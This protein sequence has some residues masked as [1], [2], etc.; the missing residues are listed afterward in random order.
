MGSTKRYQ[1]PLG[2]IN[3]ASLIVGIVGTQAALAHGV[4]PSAS[5]IEVQSCR[6]TSG[7]RT[8]LKVDFTNVKAPA[9]DKVHFAVSYGEQHFELMDHGTFSKD[10]IIAHQFSVPYDSSVGSTGATCAVTYVH[11]V[12]GSTW[13]RHA[14]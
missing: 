12:D 4:M 11:F 8:I 2:L 3:V 14:P 7:R 6:V 13:T 1:K 5:P 9:A 10:A